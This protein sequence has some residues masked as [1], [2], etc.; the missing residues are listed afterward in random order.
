MK[1]FEASK[2]FVIYF[3]LRLLT[4]A[5]LKEVQVPNHTGLTKATGS[6][7]STFF[8]KQEYASITINM[9][10]GPTSNFDGCDLGNDVMKG[11]NGKLRTFVRGHL[12]EFK[13]FDR[14]RSPKI[15]ILDSFDAFNAVKVPL[16]RIYPRY[17][18]IVLVNGFFNETKVMV[19]EIWRNSIIDVSFLVANDTHASVYT[20]FPFKYGKCGTDMSLDLINTF[21]FMTDKWSTNDFYPDKVENLNNCTLTV[22]VTESIP[23]VIINNDTI[24]DATFEGI[25]VLLIE[26]L[27]DCFNFKPSFIPFGNIGSVKKNTS[28]GVLNAVLKREIDIAIGTL[29]LQIDRAE[30]MSAT[31]MFTS[32]PIILVIPAPSHILP[33]KKLFLPFDYTTWILLFVIFATGYAVIVITKACSVQLYRLIVGYRVSFPFTNMLIAFIGQSQHHLPKANFSRFLLGKF[34]IFCLIIRSMYQGKLYDIMKKDIF[35]KMPESFDDLMAKDYIFYT[36]E[37]LSSRVQ[38]FKFAHK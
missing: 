14:R 3:S 2:F 13:P 1:S 19:K 29:S 32:T 27:G 31:T 12:R 23:M 21:D 33:F 11:I 22:G 4:E 15:L 18:L 35:Q 34:L 25:E 26:N 38:G 37:S 17:Y 5:K 7:I 16:R 6:F 36:Y 8:L 20:Y 10:M 28:T 24:K 30:S 9:A